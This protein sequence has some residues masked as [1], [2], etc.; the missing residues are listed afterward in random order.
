MSV[1]FPASFH[2]FY[3]IAFFPYIKSFYIFSLRDCLI[4]EK[5]AIG[6]GTKIGEGCVISHSVIGNNCVIGKHICGLPLEFPLASFMI[7]KLPS[8]QYNNLEGQV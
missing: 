4:K 6:D 8:N 3:F 1:F 5:V 2:I 7:R